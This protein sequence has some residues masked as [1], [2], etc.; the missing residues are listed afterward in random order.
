MFVPSTSR[1]PD[2]GWSTPPIRFKRVVL[3]E[4]DGPIS[5][6]KEPS[7]IDSDRPSSTRSCSVCR[8]YTFTTLRTSTAAIVRSLRYRGSVG[9]ELH[10]AAVL[11]TCRRREHEALAAQEPL[12]HLDAIAAR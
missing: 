2:V 10:L 3:P 5:A 1:S 12:P 11:Q 4:P 7:G 8:R 6:T 9:R